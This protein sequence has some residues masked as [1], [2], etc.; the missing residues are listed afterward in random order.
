MTEGGFSYYP[1]DAEW[2]RDEKWQR[3]LQRSPYEV[4]RALGGLRKILTY[5]SVYKRSWHTH[6]LSLDYNFIQARW[7]LLECGLM[8]DHLVLLHDL[9][10]RILEPTSYPQACAELRGGLLLQELGYSVEYEPTKLKAARRRPPKGPDWSAEHEGVVLGVEVK[11]PRESD[12]QRAMMKAVS[13]IYYL[14]LDMCRGDVPNIDVRPEAIRECVRDG[15]VIQERLS[16]LVLDAMLEFEA[17]G[18]CETALGT[19]R[20]TESGFSPMIGPIPTDEPYELE[21]LRGVLVNHI[22]QV[23]TWDTGAFIIDTGLDRSAMRRCCGIA[24][25]LREDWASNIAFVLLVA[26]TFPGFVVTVVPGPKFKSAPTL[27]SARCFNGHC[28]VRTF[29]GTYRCEVDGRFFEYPAV[30]MGN[31][32]HLRLEGR[33][34]R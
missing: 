12:R 7:R 34:R 25:M 23:R 26:D 21:R 8:L 17:R 4:R 14:A 6:G 16:Q 13:D 24:A 15:A 11:C 32:Q 3:E 5:S 30:C 27:R 29:Q 2:D 22:D 20:P 28:H 1:L 10:Q 31:G 33:A 18:A 9:P 19:L